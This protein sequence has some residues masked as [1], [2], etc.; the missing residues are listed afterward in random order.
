MLSV[1]MKNMVRHATAGPKWAPCREREAVL[2]PDGTISLGDMCAYKG[3][4]ILRTSPQELY[5]AIQAE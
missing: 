1:A 4:R 5:D 2:R 3:F